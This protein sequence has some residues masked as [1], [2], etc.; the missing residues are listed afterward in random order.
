MILLSL[1]YCCLLLRSF[2]K[3]DT[4]ITRKNVPNVGSAIQLGELYDATRDVLLIKN[5]YSRETI[6]NNS[7]DLETVYS[8]TRFLVEESY[9]DRINALDVDLALELSLMG[10]FIQISG[11]SLNKYCC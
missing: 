5:L 4:P 11:L 3:A 10:G 6:E 7:T 1:I 8:N 9:L 2:T